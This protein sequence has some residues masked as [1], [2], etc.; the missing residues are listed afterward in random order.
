MCKYVP[1]QKCLSVETFLFKSVSVLKVSLLK[2][3]SV[4]EKVYVQKVSVCQNVCASN[5]KNKNNTKGIF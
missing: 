3:E 5:N 4:F 2:K 1:V